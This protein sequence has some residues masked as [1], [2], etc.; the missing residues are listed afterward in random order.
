MPHLIELSI[1][2]GSSW[3]GL[4]ELN[5]LLAL[6]LLRKL[7]LDVSD[8][9]GLKELSQLRELTMERLP[10]EWLVWMCQPPHSLQ[11]EALTVGLALGEIEMRALINLPT[12]TSLV[13]RAL[14][15]SAWPLLPQLPHLRCLTI[16]PGS[17]LTDEHTTI[18]SESLVRCAGLEDLTF[19]FYF[20]Q[21][22]SEEDQRACWSLLLPSLP[23]LR[24]LC[25]ETDNVGPLLTVLSAH[26]PR[27]EQLVLQ[28]WDCN[29][30][31]LTQLAHPTLQELEVDEECD[32]TE[33]QMHALLHTP[34]LP[35]LRSC[36]S[37]PST[38]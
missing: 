18:L 26:L 17:A 28:C 30:V 21:A 12:L 23:N 29:A 25:V 38:D 10:S 31:A 27:L 20:P 9:T 11:L 2:H 36:K 22:T 6:P 13:S 15:P 7:T 34:R 8:V 35:Q 3:N 37:R 1:S 5:A 16:F 14:Y 19:S 33:E 4:L 24:R 32:V